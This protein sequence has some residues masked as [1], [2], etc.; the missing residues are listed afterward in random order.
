[1]GPEMK[2]KD[3]VQFEAWAVTQGL[4][5]HWADSVNDY[6]SNATS[7]AYRAWLEARRERKYHQGFN[8]RLEEVCLRLGIK[9][10]EDYDHFVERLGRLARTENDP[11][12]ISLANAC[13]RIAKEADEKAEPIVVTPSNWTKEQYE[14]FQQLW[15]R[16]VTKEGKLHFVPEVPP[17][18]HPI[19]A[20]DFSTTLNEGYPFEPNK[21]HCA[22]M[23]KR[24]AQAIESGQIQV[25]SVRQ[26]SL[27]QR[28]YMTTSMLTF[29]LVE[30]RSQEKAAQEV[31]K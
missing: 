8:P 18:P 29:N 9:E 12:P 13:R 17:L 30:K 25:Q 1:M 3:R 14:D 2:G 19:T 21:T 22:F 27:A 7:Y 20:Y 11:Q 26:R 4:E 15:E 24:L 31:P 6:A 23:L 28:E 16:L 5:L 10:G